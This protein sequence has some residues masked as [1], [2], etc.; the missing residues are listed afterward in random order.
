M[1]CGCG[2]KQQQ[3]QQMGMIARPFV[4]RMKMKITVRNKQT[5]DFSYSVNINTVLQGEIK[6]VAAVAVV[7]KMEYRQDLLQ[8]NQ[9]LLPEHPL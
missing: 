9:E 2:Q 5:R 6:W 8:L 1:A 7:E 4:P 3:Q